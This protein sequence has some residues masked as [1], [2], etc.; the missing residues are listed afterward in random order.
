MTFS[1]SCLCGTITYSVSAKID[2]T[3]LCHCS[4]CKK[5]SG[6]A[7]SAN[8][9]VPRDSFKLQTG[10]PSYYDTIGTSGKKNRHFF[11]TKCG[12]SLYAELDVMADKTVLKAGTLEGEDSGMNGAVDIEFFTKDRSP[13][14]RVIDEAKQVDGF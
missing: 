13:Y 14:L 3:A 11:C 10:Q 5:W 2:T 12:S 6:S 7:F 9:I 8:A 4:D 1:G